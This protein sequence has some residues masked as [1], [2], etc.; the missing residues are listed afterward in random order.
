MAND[1][2]SE[3][4]PQPS[5]IINLDGMVHL[6]AT[7]DGNLAVTTQD[8]VTFYPTSMKVYK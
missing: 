7:K 6:N 5:C 3:I 2:Y 1:M 4:P 8:M